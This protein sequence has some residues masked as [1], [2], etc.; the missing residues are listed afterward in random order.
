MIQP[1][2][3]PMPLT[4]PPTVTARIPHARSASL[5]PVLVHV[6]FSKLV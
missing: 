4:F 1:P 5:V 6:S 2:T 3:H